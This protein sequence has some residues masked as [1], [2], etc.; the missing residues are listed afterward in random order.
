MPDVT[1]DEDLKNELAEIA[2]G[3]GCELLDARFQ[4]GVVK[5][6]LDHPDGVTLTHC[7]TV[8]KQASAQ[9]DVRDWGSSKYTL[10]VS[11]PGLDRELFGPRDFARFT[12]SQV[13]VTWH[14]DQ[15]KRTDVGMLEKFIPDNEN[16][17]G[18]AEIEI[19][20]D[21]DALRRIPLQSIHVA[22]LVPEL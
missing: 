1:F 18:R 22:R 12:G 6:V 19:R 2:R 15:G 5:L 8:S 14:S 10:E 16:A 3:S 4:G 11:S 7:Q 9:L 13:K 21:S 17:E 20:L